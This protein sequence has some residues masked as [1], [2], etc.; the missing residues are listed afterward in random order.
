M[1][2]SNQYFCGTNNCLNASLDAMNIVFE[3]GDMPNGISC[4]APSLKDRE[5]YPV[6][7]A[8]LPV[9]APLSCATGSSSYGNTLPREHTN[10]SWI[11]DGSVR[12]T[13]YNDFVG[14]LGAQGSF[15]EPF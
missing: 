8:L 15:L 1:L 12:D 6:S 7:V 9:R 3:H 14:F 2:W 13:V 11:Y 5:P 4:N 10:K